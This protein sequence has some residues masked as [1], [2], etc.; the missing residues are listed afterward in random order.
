MAK[1]YINIFQS[2]AL[3]NLPKMGIFGLK[4]N[5]LATL[6]PTD[7]SEFV[8]SRDVAQH[9]TPKNGLILLLCVV[10]YD[11]SSSVGLCEQ[12]IYITRSL[13]SEASSFTRKARRQLAPRQR[14][15]AKERNIGTLARRETFR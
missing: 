12:T 4:I 3:K 13:I 1:K 8:T 2:K 6:I 9:D 15:G 10:P 5:H 11:T 14:L 7:I